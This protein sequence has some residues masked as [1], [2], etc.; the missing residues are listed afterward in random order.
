MELLPS[1]V[2]HCRLL[3]KRRRKN[4]SRQK[5]TF[6]DPDIVKRKSYESDIAQYTVC[7]SFIEHSHSMITQ[8]LFKNGDSINSDRSVARLQVLPLLGLWINW[9][10]SL[11]IYQQMALFFLKD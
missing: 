10:I 3:I 7:V 1:G 2:F 5:H 8:Q 6:S 11:P 9:K 4:K